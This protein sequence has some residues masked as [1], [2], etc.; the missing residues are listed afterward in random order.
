[1]ASIQQSMNQ[2]PVHYTG[3]PVSPH[4]RVRLLAMRHPALNS[5]RASLWVDWTTSKE[6]N[7]AISIYRLLCSKREPI[8]IRTSR[9]KSGTR[10]EDPSLL[11]RPLCLPSYQLTWTIVDEA[12]RA[13][14]EPLKKGDRFG[15]SW[16]NHWVKCSIKVPKE[17]KEK[18]RIQL[19]FDP[20][21]VFQLCLG[22]MLMAVC[23]NVQL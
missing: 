15:P 19:E 3:E 23:G 5:R 6:A 7:T 10:K 12:V 13:H 8:P 11:V 22:V 21:H 2:L 18:E 1:M 14:Y 17:W 16:T 4:F 9:L 20:R